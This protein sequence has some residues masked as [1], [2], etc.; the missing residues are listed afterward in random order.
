MFFQFSLH[1]YRE[2][3]KT[4]VTQVPQAPL[5]IDSGECPAGLCVAIL[6]AYSIT[7]KALKVSSCNDQLPVTTRYFT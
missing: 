1:G 5:E 7:V 4:P 6:L 2:G 3:C